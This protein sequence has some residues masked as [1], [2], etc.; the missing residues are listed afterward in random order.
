MNT[1]QLA[2]TPSEIPLA[3]DAA[4]KRTSQQVRRVPDK[5]PSAPHAPPPPFGWSPP[6]AL[7]AGRKRR[8]V[9]AMRSASELMRSPD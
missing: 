6:P 4:S 3:G 7:R 1:V 9:L 8:F 5:E 2:R